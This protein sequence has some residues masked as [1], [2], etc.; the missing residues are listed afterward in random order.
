MKGVVGLYFCEATK[1]ENARR[2][3]RELEVVFKLIEDS[4]LGF[5]YIKGFHISVEV[6][7]NHPLV[8]LRAK[9]QELVF[10]VRESESEQGTY[11]FLV[12]EYDNYAWD[13]Y[14]EAELN[15]ACFISGYLN[16]YLIK[17]SKSL[18]FNKA[19]FRVWFPNA[20][21]TYYPDE[22]PVTRDFLKCK[23]FVSDKIRVSTKNRY[24]VKV[25]KLYKIPVTSLKIT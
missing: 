9:K 21:N 12:Y 22:F 5:F 14:P 4:L 18:D 10:E 13:Y 8:T 17:V 23:D 16:P 25:A 24:Q 15:L 6:I 11:L 19:K 3:L 20:W 1:I 7:D 2:Y